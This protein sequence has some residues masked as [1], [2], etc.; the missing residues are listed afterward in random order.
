M[1]EP[2]SAELDVAAYLRT[3]MLRWARTTCACASSRRRLSR[4]P[5]PF[6]PANPRR[7]AHL[8]P[9]PA[10]EA[11]S[12]AISLRHDEGLWVNYLG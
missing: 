1:P 3:Q 5:A 7:L 4:G 10:A 2:T 11:P 6:D 9:R 8:R 12:V